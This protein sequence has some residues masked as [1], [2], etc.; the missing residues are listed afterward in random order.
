VNGLYDKIAGRQDEIERFDRY[1]RGEQSLKYASD[2]WREFH[3]QRYAR[4]ADNWCGVVTDA[5]AQRLKVDGIQ[6]DGGSD[7]SDAERLLWRD[8]QRNDLE[9]QSAQG[10]LETLK[11][12][13]SF[14][15][16]WPGP[17][18]PVAT[19]EDPTQVAVAY[20]PEFPGRRTAALKTWCDEDNEYATLYTADWLYKF[21]RPLRKDSAL[22]MPESVRRKFKDEQGWAVREPAGESWPLR[23]PLGV[24]PIVEVRN[25]GPLRGDPLSEIGGVVP[26]QDAINLLWAYLFTSA[27]HASFPAR[28]VLG[29]EQPS[30]PKL[31]ENGQ[32]TGQRIPVDLK[33]LANG[34]LLFLNEDGASPSIDQWDAAKLDVFTEVIEVSV[35]H[36]AAQTRTPQHYLILGRNANPAAAEALTAAEAGLNAKVKD[37]Q[38]FMGADLREVNRLFALARQDQA[39]ADLVSAGS[40]VWEDSENRSEAQKADAATKWASVGM[41]LESLVAKFWSRDPAEV[42]RIMEMAE[43]EADDPTMARIMKEFRRTE[44][45]TDDADDDAAVG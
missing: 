9:R 2:I 11:S 32:D 26:M 25:R 44:P 37:L 5:P 40:I 21:V 36:I 8:W 14:V 15:L 4:F 3:A 39:L 20:D 45:V 41:P 38:L 10:I 1:Y 24:V 23:N 43:R 13:R 30:V 28:V 33:S 31:D 34:R 27:D 12:R 16:V 22:A 17:D 18:G 42:A 29:M 7:Y 19:W 6:L 35:G